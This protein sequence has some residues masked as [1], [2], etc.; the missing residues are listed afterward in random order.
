MNATLAAPESLTVVRSHTGKVWTRDEVRA[1]VERGVFEEAQ[2][3]LLEG[4][5]FEKKMA[6]NR[7]HSNHSSAIAD[8]CREVFGLKRVQTEV[9][10]DVSSADTP[11]SEP[12]PDIVVLARPRFDYP[13]SNP[14][15]SD[16]LLVVEVASTTLTRDLGD[17]AA[18]YARA[19]IADYWVYNIRFRQMIVHRD[20]AEGRYRAVEV[21]S[22]SDSVAPL[23]AP[24][25][26][27]P[28]RAAFE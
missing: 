10:I 25:R 11:T 19:E 20:P 15:P 21:Y 26:P 9:P 13:K 16:V 22:E 28:V 18:L 7:P 5:L 4:Q 24:D 3:E 27:F 1:L 14:S 23:A 8:W 17:K 12:E 2:Y 6:K